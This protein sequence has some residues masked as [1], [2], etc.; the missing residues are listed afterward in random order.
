MSMDSSNIKSFSWKMVRLKYF[1]FPQFVEKIV[2][3]V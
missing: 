1:R 2:F 3:I